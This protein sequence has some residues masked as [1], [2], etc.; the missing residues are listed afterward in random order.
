MEK[1]VTLV[2]VGLEEVEFLVSIAF[3]GD[4]KLLNE[5]HISPGTLDHCVKHTFGFIETNAGHYNDDIKFYSVNYD[6]QMIGYTV[7]VLNEKE[8]NELYSFGINKS[9][10]TDEV[11]E[12]WL[13]AVKEKLNNY[14]YVVLWAKNTRAINFFERHG[15][16]VD[17]TDKYQGDPTKTLI[18]SDS[19]VY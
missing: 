17:R 10:R 4:D 1:R 3:N 8:P 15:F 19:I 6:K 9:H 7:I 14:F 16:K 11:R 5:Y 18:V 12:M 2:P 13:E